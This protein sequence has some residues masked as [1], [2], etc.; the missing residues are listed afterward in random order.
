ML[1]AFRVFQN[2]RAQVFRG[3]QMTFLAFGFSHLNRA[4]VRGFLPNIA[5]F[6]RPNLAREI[7]SFVGRMQLFR[8]ALG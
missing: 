4:P 1:K 3:F 5:N 6:G 2:R 7:D 8:V